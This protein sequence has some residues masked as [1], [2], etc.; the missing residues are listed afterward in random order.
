MATLLLILSI[1]IFS[2]GSEKRFDGKSTANT[3]SQESAPVKMPES[4]EAL[5]QSESTVARAEAFTG[6][7]TYMTLIDATHPLPENYEPELTRLHDWDLSVASCAYDCLCDM[8]RAGRE[9]GLSFQICSAYRTHEEQEKLF[10]D[11]VAV[12]MTAGM[13]EEEALA[14]TSLYTMLPGCSEHESGLALDIVSLGYQLLDDAQEETPETKWLYS[15]CA[16][17]GFILRYPKEKADITGIAYEP[18][19]YRY[20]GKE[21]AKYLTEHQLTLEEYWLQPNQ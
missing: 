10:N 14:E 16:E 8:L 17:Y 4:S 13:S 9:A 5:K 7:S 2:C 18:W 15:H 3:P 1:S 12:R 21:A 20:V 6:D 11:D 19:H